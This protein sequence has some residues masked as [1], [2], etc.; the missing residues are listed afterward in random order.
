MNL[1]S[2]RRGPWAAQGEALLRGSWNVEVV[3]TRRRHPLIDCQ[4]FDARELTPADRLPAAGDIPG[5]DSCRGPASLATKPLTAQR[6]EIRNAI[7]ENIDHGLQT[8]W[9]RTNIGQM[10]FSVMDS[11]ANIT[12]NRAAAA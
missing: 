11:S 12:P 8:V 10:H 2:G 9:G 6:S 5:Q 7:A 3:A 4:E 1:S